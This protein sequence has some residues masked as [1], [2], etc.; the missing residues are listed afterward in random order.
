MAQVNV[1]YEPQTQTQVLTIFW[2]APQ[3]DQICPELDNGLVLIKNGQTGD[4]IALEIL[5]Y[6]PTDA[7]FDNVSVHIGQTTPGASLG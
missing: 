3:P 5:S 1:F 2:Q 4:A 7:R 6:R